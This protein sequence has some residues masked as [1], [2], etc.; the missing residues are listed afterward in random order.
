[1]ALLGGGNGLG[2]CT[3]TLLSSDS[4]IWGK[5]QR[6]FFV[7]FSKSMQTKPVPWWK[8]L[9]MSHLDR[10]TSL[11]GGWWK[12]AQKAEPLQDVLLKPPS[13]MQI[14][15][16]AGFLCS[17]WSYLLKTLL[18]RIGK[19]NAYGLVLSESFFSPNI[20]QALTHLSY[21]PETAFHVNEVDFTTVTTVSCLF[22]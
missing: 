11:L 17:P 5:T 18:S 14:L 8:F 4:C 2:S 7:Q 15:L 20:A 12:Q 13:H 1:M 21:P 16:R 9:C 6:Y 22:Q 3:H 10:R 19:Q